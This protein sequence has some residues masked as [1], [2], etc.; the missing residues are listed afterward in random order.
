MGLEG[1]GGGGGGGGECSNKI[2]LSDAV[3][4]SSGLYPSTFS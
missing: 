4:L 3:E 1:G 2:W